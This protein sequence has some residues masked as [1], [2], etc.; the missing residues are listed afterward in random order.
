MRIFRE[1]DHSFF[2]YSKREKSVKTKYSQMHSGAL[3]ICHIITTIDMGGAEKQLLALAT[4]QVKMGNS[5]EV[6]YLKDEPVLIEHFLN[7]GIDINGKLAGLPFCQQ[8]IELRR[9]AKGRLKDFVIHAHLPRSEILCAISLPRGKF[10]ITRHNSEHFVPSVPLWFSKLTSKMVLKR[11]FYAIYISIAVKRFYEECGEAI[12]TSNSTVI[13]YG[14]DS[15]ISS[16]CRLTLENEEPV[17]IGTIARL[18]PQ[19]NLKLLLDIGRELIR[20]NFIHFQINILGT[21]DL[22][23][24]LVEYAKRA[25]LTQHV[26]WLARTFDVEAF[27]RKQDIFVLTSNYEGFGLVLLEAM[28]QQLPIL[29]RNISS[30]PEVL[31]QNH[32]GLMDSTDPSVWTKA[33]V[34]LFK[35]QRKVKDFIHYQESQL[36]KFSIQ[37]TY[38]QHQN[39]Y[40]RMQDQN[41][42]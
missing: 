22:K 24:D 40:F 41:K 42:L 32:P 25:E 28:Q 29:A 12:P 23:D 17:Q 20:E 18:V 21:G 13:Y 26:N 33:I 1:N 35:D 36:L 38:M 4:E 34:A 19:K 16:H 27:Y 6:I 31:G 37:E 2:S 30:I 7:C 10:V 11:A 39:I 8:V 15:K 3:K 14:T 5:V 9:L